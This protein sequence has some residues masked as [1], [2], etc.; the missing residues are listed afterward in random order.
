MIPTHP[1]ASNPLRAPTIACKDTT[2]AGADVSEAAGS[3]TLDASPH[4][5]SFEV[6]PGAWGLVRFQPCAA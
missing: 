1:P 2:L 6:R 5:H 3:G 4:V